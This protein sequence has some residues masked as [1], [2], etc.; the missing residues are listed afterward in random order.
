M[1]CHI[2]SCEPL[3][4]C[5]SAVFTP[6]LDF[7]GEYE[8]TFDNVRTGFSYRVPWSSVR[9][10]RKR[11]E[12][13]EATVSTVPLD[14]PAW[15]A[16][17]EVIRALEPW[18][19]AL[20]IRRDGVLVWTGPITGFSRAEFAA[21][22]PAMIEIRARDM[23][24][25]WRKR[26]V[27]Q[28]RTFTSTDIGSMVEQLLVDAYGVAGSTYQP[29][30]DIGE[31]GIIGGRTYLAADGENIFDAVSEIA[32]RGLTWTMIGETLIANPVTFQAASDRCGILTDRAFASLPSVEVE[33]L[34]QANYFWVRGTNVNRSYS[35]VDED[36]GLLQRTEQRDDIT[37]NGDADAFGLEQYER[38]RFPVVTVGSAVL[39]TRVPIA[40]ADLVPGIN[41]SLSF[42]ESAMLGVADVLGVVRFG[43]DAISVEVS[44][45]NDGVSE[46]VSMSI[47]YRTG[48]VT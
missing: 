41:V 10:D 37:T 15:L 27:A 24:A 11:N 26:L 7:D 2:R 38:F 44:S 4:V 5:V 43:V 18:V 36:V 39:S 42:E 23:S 29:T 25:L 22:Q 47:G 16:A 6:V 20:R 12:V 30:L 21:G 46:K 3:G 34:E 1:D 48:G 8:V 13:S 28:N 19:C 33:G 31:W 32:E 45:G 40:F 35:L 14:G 17:T 9:W